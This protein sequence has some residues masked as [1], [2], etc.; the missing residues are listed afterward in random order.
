MNPND[1]DGWLWDIRGPQDPA[2]V[3]WGILSPVDDATLCC[4]IESWHYGSAEDGEI[5]GLACEL[6]AARF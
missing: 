2:A 3:D 4:V 5:A 1:P 6:T